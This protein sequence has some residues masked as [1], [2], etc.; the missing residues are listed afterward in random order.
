MDTIQEKNNPL[1]K[2]LGMLKVPDLTEYLPI[3]MLLY[4]YMNKKGPSSFKDFLNPH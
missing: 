2:S 1:F 3:L 4:N